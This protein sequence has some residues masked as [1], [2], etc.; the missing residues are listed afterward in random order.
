MTMR[1]R[2]R[3]TRRTLGAALIALARGAAVRAGG[4][5][6]ATVREK[7]GASI[8][9]I[10]AAQVEKAEVDQFVLYEL[11]WVGNTAQLGPA[12]Q[13]HLGRIIQR[14]PETNYSVIIQM[15]VDEAV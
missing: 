6:P 1:W 13:Y 8:H 7:L 12:G 10:M 14:L 4:V 5:T 15:H 11:E 2:P 9:R 3:L